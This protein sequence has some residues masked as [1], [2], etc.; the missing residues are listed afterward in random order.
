MKI[1]FSIK[2]Y[3]GLHTVEYHSPSVGMTLLATWNIED[4]MKELARWES[5]SK[6]EAE[7]ELLNQ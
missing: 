6:E 7:K 4:A 2:T 1:G 5:M 3:K